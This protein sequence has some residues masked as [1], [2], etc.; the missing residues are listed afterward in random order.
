MG[1]TGKVTPYKAGFGPFPNEIYHAPYPNAFHGVTIEQSLAA[2]QDLF[3]CDIEPSRVAAVIFEPVQGEGGF[4]QAPNE[5]AKAIRALCDQHGIMLIADEIQTGFARTG[6][7]FATEYL[8][9]EPDMMTLAKGIAGGYPI[10]AVVGKA[11][12]MDSALPGGLGGT[13]AGSP[14]GCVAGLEVLKIIEEEQLCHKALGVG[15]VVDVYLNRL[16]ETV[17]EIGDVRTLGA[18][19]AIELTDPETGAPLPDLTKGVIA[20]AQEH[21][22]ILLSCGVKANVIRLL[23]ALTIETTTLVDGLDCL[24]SVFMAA[25]RALK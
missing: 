6:K 20:L 4:Y 15:E 11:D 21:G 12:V 3:A 7:M 10:S 2:I 22:L 16:K 23:P 9:I 13:Y 1:L 14:L 5:W 19:I 8:D 17:P 25:T 24:A 18:M